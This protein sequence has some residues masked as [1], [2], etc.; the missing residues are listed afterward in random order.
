MFNF[1]Y[2]NFLTAFENPVVVKLPLIIFAIVFK[3]FVYLY[4]SMHGC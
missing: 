4:V 1:Y 2:I 3:I